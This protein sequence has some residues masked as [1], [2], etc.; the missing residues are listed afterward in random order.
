ML[1]VG[2]LVANILSVDKFN[3][4]YRLQYKTLLVGSKSWRNGCMRCLN[5]HL[6]RVFSVELIV[7]AIVVDR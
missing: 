3:C 7:A 2:M 6:S 4:D 1:R 5:S